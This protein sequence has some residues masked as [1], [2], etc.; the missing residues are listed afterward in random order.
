MAAQ[1]PHEV[2]AYCSRL[3]A[4]PEHRIRAIVGDVGGAFGQKAGVM[5]EE[6]A[7]VLA[8]RVL[9][10][11][12][13][14][15]EDRWENLTSGHHA[16]E[17]EMDIAVAVDG[18]GTLLAARLSHTEN[19]GAYPLSGTMSIGPMVGLMFPGPYRLPQLSFDNKAVYTNTCGRCCVRGPW[20]FETVAREMMVDIVARAYGH[21]PARASAPQRP[22]AGRPAVHV[23]HRE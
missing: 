8:S 20:M 9:G 21:G 1:N 19:V 5:R 10:R 3:L 6:A 17:D 22:P 11:P 7:V 12:V 15:I 23:A 2:R 16:R 13:K 4:V 14:W 18:A